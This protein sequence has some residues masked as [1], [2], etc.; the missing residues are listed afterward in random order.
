MEGQGEAG[1][2]V[3]AVLALADMKILYP[4]D[5]IVI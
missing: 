2:L 3:L 5:V 4:L 1:N